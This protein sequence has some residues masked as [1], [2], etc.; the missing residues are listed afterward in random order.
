MSNDIPVECTSCQAA[1]NEFFGYESMSTH[2]FSQFRERYE[3]AALH[4]F[5]SDHSCC[6]KGSVFHR[7]LAYWEAAEEKG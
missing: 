6:G 3:S 7:C 5:P 1:I 4:I 2:P